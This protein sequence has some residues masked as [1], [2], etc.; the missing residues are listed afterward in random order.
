MSLEEANRYKEL[1][2]KEVAEKNWERAIGYYSKAIN[3]SRNAIFFSNRALCLFNLKKYPE[4]VQDARE[5]IALDPKYVK[6]YLRGA[7]ALI[8]MDNFAD[9]LAMIQRGIDENPDN[10][11][12]RRELES[13]EIIYG[14]HDAVQNHI[15]REEWADAV[16]KLDVLIEKMPTNAKL[17]R[18]KITALCNNNEMEKAKSTLAANEALLQKDDQLQLVLLSAMVERFS[19][20]LTAALSIL[21][22]GARGFPD[23]RE[24]AEALKLVQL[25][26]SSKKNGNDLVGRKDYG[27]AMSAYQS[28]LAL[29]PKNKMYCAIILAN[30]ATCLMGLK[31][32]KE[33]LSSIKKATEMNPKYANGWF[34]RAEIEKGLQEY[35]SALQSYSTAKNL[36]PSLNIDAKTREVSH[37][38]KNQKQ[39]DFYE[40]LGLKKENSPTL[41]D[42]KK[43]YKKM[44]FKYHPDKNTGSKEEQEEAEKKFKEVS[45]AHEVLSDPEKR[46][47]Y[48]MGAYS[49]GG[50]SQNFDFSDMFS[51]H[52]G[53]PGHGGQSFKMFFEPGGKSFNMGSGGFGGFGGFDDDMPSM[54]RSR[55]SGGAR[56]GNPF[57][58]MGGMGG[59]GFDIN[60][61]LSRMGGNRR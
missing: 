17:L 20:N 8:A 38:I 30:I 47:R 16:R 25:M 61:L 60:D 28:A 56:S 46:R 9:G 3:L 1:G 15:Q 39:K 48:D 37:H 27:A 49:S 34:K 2:N 33:A 21:E 55:T 52:S 13:Y 18:L 35:D 11:D 42:I 57:G 53:H 26:E 32:E 29:D 4:A 10:V 50:G 31:R 23:S 5:A 43:A 59:M 41:D 7:H 58:G 45:E 44:V 24:L 14:Y 51:G 19:N 12:L 36:D 40:V 54:F 22:R 6:A